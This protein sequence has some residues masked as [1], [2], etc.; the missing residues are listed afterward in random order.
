MSRPIDS[1][2][3]VNSLLSSKSSRNWASWPIDSGSSRSFKSFKSSSVAPV[4]AASS[5][6]CSAICSGVSSGMAHYRTGRAH[7]YPPNSLYREILPHWAAAGLPP[8]RRPRPDQ[9]RATVH[10]RWRLRLARREGVREQETEPGT[11]V[12]GQVSSNTPC[13]VAPTGGQSQ[14]PKPNMTFESV[15]W[16]SACGLSLPLPPSLHRPPDSRPCAF[17]A[18]TLSVPRRDFSRRL[19]QFA[20]LILLQPSPCSAGP[21]REAPRLLSPSGPRHTTSKISSHS[22]HSTY[23]A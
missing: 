6:R 2:R 21:R 13:A 15:A 8:K 16:I 20:P 23:H 11:Q 17:V 9:D 22:F 3:A 4:R 19:G 1:G 14:R 10:S 7:C 5:I 18:H 12:T